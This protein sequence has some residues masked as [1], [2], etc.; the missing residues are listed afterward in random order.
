M[1]SRYDIALNNNDPLADGGD[2]V[3]AVSDDQHIIDTLNAFP[4]W[5]K[6]DPQD[7]IGIQSWKKGPAQAQE[8]SK[9]MRIQLE[10]DGYTLINPTVT[11]SPAGQFIINPNATI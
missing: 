8:L 3:C 10:S 5:W 1:A 11:L 4:G 7:G 9:Q 6:Q 2:F